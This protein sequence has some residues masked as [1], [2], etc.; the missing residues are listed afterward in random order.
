MTI[1]FVPLQLGQL[2][3]SCCIAEKERERE[4]SII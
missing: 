4:R 2:T 1:R 3:M